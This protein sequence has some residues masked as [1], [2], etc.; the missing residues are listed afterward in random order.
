MSSPPLDLP[1]LTASDV[2][3]SDAWLGR[4][5]L[6]QI[7][8]DVACTKIAVDLQNIERSQ[9]DDVLRRSLDA[10]AELTGSDC[11]FIALIDEQRSIGEVHA[12]RRGLAPSQPEGLK[13]LPLA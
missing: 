6:P 5:E 7:G 12:S 1:E 11:A 8:L 9:A 4:A 13:G 10:L 2:L 3:A